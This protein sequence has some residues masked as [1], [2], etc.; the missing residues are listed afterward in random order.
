[1]MDIQAFSCMDALTKVT[2]P[3]MW[4]CLDKSDST[5][6]VDMLNSKWT[7]FVRLKL[8]WIMVNDESFVSRLVVM[9]FSNELNIGQQRY[10]EEPPEDIT[11]SIW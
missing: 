5:I 6:D 2:V 1:M 9:M 3:L 10:I 4:T 7:K 8:G 11:P